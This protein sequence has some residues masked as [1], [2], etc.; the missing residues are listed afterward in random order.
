MTL[1]KNFYALAAHRRRLLRGIRTISS[2]NL[3]TSDIRRN[4]MIMNPF[5]TGK[6][7][8]P[9]TNRNMEILDRDFFQKTIPVTAA[10]IVEKRKISE[11]KKQLEQSDGALKTI[12]SDPTG[13]SAK[14]VLLK[15][16][17]RKDDPST[18]S[19]YLKGLIDAK[20]VLLR[21]FNLR[22][23]YE[24][25]T[26]QQ[27]LSAVLPELPDDEQETPAGFAQAGHV[28]H[29][30]LRSQY[31]PYKYLI[32]QV[33]LDKNPQ[34]RTVIN[35]TLQV[36][37]ESE[38]RTFPYEVLAGED[39]LDVV[40]SESGCEFHFN[41]AKV[42]WNTRLQTEHLRLYS[43]FKQGEAVCDVMAGV[44]PF[45][46]PA[47]KNRIFVHANDLNPDSYAALQDAITR[48]KVEDFVTASCTDGR[49][50]IRQ[51]A[52]ALR[53]HQ[54]SVSVK[55]KIKISRGASNAERDQIAA[56]VVAG[57]RTYREPTSFNHYIMN[58][59]AIAVEFLDA[60]RGVYHGRK[61]EFDEA[62]GRPLP[63]IHVYLF[64]KPVPGEDEA[65][66][67]LERISKHLGYDLTPQHKS[68][69]M[70]LLYVRLVG[71][72]K[73]YYCASFRLPPEVAFA[74]PIEP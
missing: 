74:E 21:D 61:N 56:K 55:P 17:V 5:W 40:V 42:Y 49:D 19:P 44:G 50:F 69:E 54:R 16:D 73:K 4:P 20:Q 47:G 32:G 34:I 72:N 51:S 41:F 13:S 48:N 68:G 31:L 3:G 7:F 27:I 39:D 15:P 30:N 25:F 29:M 59:P 53:Q 6:A 28:A 71:P 2:I 24:D 35:K 65:D 26:M 58:L 9:P 14:C 43:K 33:L 46:V 23:T 67:I 22:I 52:K 62:G 36:G 10:S 12:H 38:F 63:M 70:E 37:H 60:F 18:W 64:H 1:A 66:A 57:T 8:E 11:F 45:A